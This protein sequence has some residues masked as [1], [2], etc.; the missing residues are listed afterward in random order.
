[1]LT[2]VLQCPDSCDGVAETRTAVCSTQEGK[3][4]PDDTCDLGRRPVVERPCSSSCVAKP[5]WHA[6]EW[7]EVSRPMT[8]SGS[9]RFVYP[10]FF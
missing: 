4:Y 3:I 5:K 2:I 6:S 1:M 9:Y 10:T 8:T 7:G